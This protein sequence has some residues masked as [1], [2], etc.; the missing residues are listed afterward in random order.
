MTKVPG[1]FDVALQL[2]APRCYSTTVS[3]GLHRDRPVA[4]VAGTTR[5]AGRA[6]AVELAPTGFFV[7]T[8]GRSSR[9]SGSSEI[10]RPETIEE[11]G[12]LIDASGGDGRTLV[13]DHE[14]SE[15]AAILKR[16]T[17]PSRRSDATRVK[18]PLRS[19][20]TPPRSTVGEAASSR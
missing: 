10:D 6:I 11:T 19:C 8:T 17:P 5:A 14:S 3:A 4:L 9:V 7:Y 18:P 13:A 2:I 1:R 20:W 15:G 12:D 16:S